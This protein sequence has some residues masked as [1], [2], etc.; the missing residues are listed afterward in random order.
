MLK[1][2]V[3]MEEQIM[4]Y[5]LKPKWKKSV[6]I[7]TVFRHNNDTTK[8]ASSDETYRYEEFE[9]ELAEGVNI[10]ELRTWD[11]FD[12]DDTDT[13][14]TYE[15]LDNPVSGDVTYCEWDTSSGVDADE[16]EMIM[17]G[18]IWDLEDWSATESYTS[19]QCECEITPAS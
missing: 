13:F 15:M 7:T 1:T 8:A 4:K 12:L 14:T 11:D 3:E 2:S 6:I 17:E 9:V 5:I 16:E 19:I 10:D 18:C